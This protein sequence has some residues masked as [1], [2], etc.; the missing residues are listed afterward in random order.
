MASTILD[1]KSV[2]APSLKSGAGESLIRAAGSDIANAGKL[3]QNEM[4]RR[5]EAEYKAQQD[6]LT[7]QNWEATFEAGRDDAKATADYRLQDLL[8]N[9]QAREMQ[10]KYNADRLALERDKASSEA[11]YRKLQAD[12]MAR[13]IAE[14]QKG[15][16]V[17]NALINT[18]T[19]TDWYLKNP[20]GSY[21]TGTGGQRIPDENAYLAFAQQ[22]IAELNKNLPEGQKPYTYNPVQ[23]RDLFRTQLGSAVATDPITQK[24]REEAAL[25]LSVANEKAK[26]FQTVSSYVEEKNDNNLRN[27][28]NNIQIKM[29][30]P[31]SDYNLLTPAEIGS[32]ISS[33]FDKGLIWDSFNESRAKQL[34]DAMALKKKTTK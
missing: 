9:Q 33:N 25:N 22:K 13:K 34:L 5:A 14:A 24:Q 31:N 18:F 26:Q 29:L 1:Y 7:Q 23:A 10:A 27:F 20:D 15:K 17:E 19:G 30:D 3:F 21:A 4:A 32:V 8:G 6:A 28:W 2:A 16:D 12:E 11:E